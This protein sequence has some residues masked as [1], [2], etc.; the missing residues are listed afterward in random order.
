MNIFEI[1]P[2]QQTPKVPVIEDTAILE[3]LETNKEVLNDFLEFCKTKP[4]AVGLA[5][6]QTSLNGERFNVNVFGIK[7]YKNWK[8]IINPKIHNYIGIKEIKVEG[9]LTWKERVVVAERSR[10]IVVSYFDING[11][12][13]KQKLISGYSSQIFQHEI[14]HLLG[15]EERIEDNFIEPKQI[16]VGR[17][18]KCHCDSGVKYKHC[19]LLLL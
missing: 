1:I 9:C 11:I 5:V 2:N 12:E 3:F 4:N 7:E 13:Y 15:I 16:S 17:N 6:N 8:L 18:D 14:N 19:C 10:G